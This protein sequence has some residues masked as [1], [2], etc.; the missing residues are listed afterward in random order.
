MQQSLEF[1]IKKLHPNLSLISEYFYKSRKKVIVKDQFNIEYDVFLTNILEGS[2]PTIQTSLNKNETF[3]KLLD[4]KNIKFKLLDN[5]INQI[6]P[7]TIIDSENFIF[8]IIPKRIME[9][10]IP[11]KNIAV[12][13][14][15]NLITI[16]KNIHNNRYNYSSIFKDRDKFFIKIECKKHGVFNQRIDTHL[17]GKNCPLCAR[18]NQP[19]FTFKN[20]KELSK[21]SNNFDS[22]KVYVLKLSKNNEVFYKIGRTFSTIDQRFKKE[23]DYNIEILNIFNSEDPKY[24]WDLENYL[25]RLHNEYKYIPNDKFGGYTECYSKI[26]IN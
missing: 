11:H 15:E 26:L 19:T 4:S 13:Y 5:Y 14:Y 21:N 17:N 25:H 2:K 18:S 10:R 12:N 20:W 8:K 7:I 9:G 16:L 23:L 1:Q 22:Y 3:Q 24:I 6:T